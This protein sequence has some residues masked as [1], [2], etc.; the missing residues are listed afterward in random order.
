MGDYF[1]SEFKI[2]EKA[3]ILIELELGP[4]VHKVSLSSEDIEKISAKASDSAM[5]TIHHM[6]RRI[7]DAIEALPNEKKPSQAEISFGIKLNAEAGALIAKAGAEASIDVQ[8][9][10]ERE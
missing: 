4:G 6:A 8:L 2:D 3:P 5:N 9:T 7:A 10:W 1:M